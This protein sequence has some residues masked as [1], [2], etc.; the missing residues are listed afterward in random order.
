MNTNATRRAGTY[1]LAGVLAVSIAGC[2]STSSAEE[3][4]D[5]QAMCALFDEVEGPQDIT[6]DYLDDLLAVA[7]ADARP[8]IEEIRAAV[9]SDGTDAFEDPEIAARFDEVGSYA[10]GTC[11][12][13]G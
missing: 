9:A 7:L 10:G 6:L 4:G 1:L 11:P 12:G 13:D 5:V 2:S 8:A 3:S